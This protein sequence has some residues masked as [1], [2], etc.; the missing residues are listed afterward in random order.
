MQSTL[1]LTPELL[2][3]IAGDKGPGKYYISR[4]EEKYRYGA[5]IK[6]GVYAGSILPVYRVVKFSW[7]GETTYTIFCGIGGRE[8]SYLQKDF[9]PN[10]L[11]MFEYF[12]WEVYKLEHK[13]KESNPNATFTDKLGFTIGVGD[14]VVY[15]DRAAKALDALHFGTITE[16]KPSGGIYIKDSIRKTYGARRVPANN[17]IKLTEEQKKHLVLKK[18]AEFQ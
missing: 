1:S 13:K 14:A 4:A 9:K 7:K 2:D 18:L 6:S 12:T 15:V 10:Q 16:I 5:K 8:K 11:E 3:T 17:I